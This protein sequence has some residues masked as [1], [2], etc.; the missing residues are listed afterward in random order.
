MSEKKP[1]IAVTR[2]IPS[3]GIRLLSEHFE[4]R[5]W[6]SDAPPPREK[7]VELLKDVDGAVTL[8]SDRIDG[9]LLDV[10]GRIKIIANMAVGYENVDVSAAADRGVWVT[11]TPDVLTDAT[12][13]I[14]M[15]LILCVTRRILESDTFMRTGRYH[16]WDPRLL[17]GMGLAGKTLGIVGFGRIGRAVAKRARAFEMEII[18][19]DPGLKRDTS[20]PEDTRQVGMDELLETSDIVSLHC[21]YMPELY[22]L[23]NNEALAKMKTTAYFINTAR[24][25]LMDEK[26]LYHALKN[27][28]IAGTGLDVYEDEP[29]FVTELADLDNVVMLP[30]IGSATFETRDAMAE[31]AARNVIAFLGGN[32][33]LT[34]VNKPKEIEK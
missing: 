14:A 20:L 30:H 31:L 9:E 24:G 28:Q 5:Q 33:P 2:L 7:L 26:A 21:P 6:E 16:H 23:I 13:D 27:G 1:L 17:R 8:L 15:S 22:H 10:C 29:E 32:E 4:L 18:F 34:P 19:N 3:A 12:A 11:N 25:K